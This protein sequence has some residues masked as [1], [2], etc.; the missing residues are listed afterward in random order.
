MVSKKV[1]NLTYLQDSVNVL[2]AGGDNVQ[3]GRVGKQ[4]NLE[5][6]NQWL[7]FFFAGDQADRFALRGNH[8]DGSQKPSDFNTVKPPENQVISANEFKKYLRTDTCNYDEVRDGD[9]LY[10]YKDYPQYKV[11]LVLVDSIDIPNIV[12]S[13]GKLKYYG[14]GQMGFQERQLKWIANEALGTCPDDYHVVMFS[15]VPIDRSQNDAGS[16]N[17]E[18]LISIIKAFMN[19]TTA[20]ITTSTVSEYSTDFSVNF[21]VDFSKRLNSNFVGYVAGHSHT[22]KVSKIEGFNV[23]VCRQSVFEDWQPAELVGTASEDAMQ[24]IQ[25]DTSNRELII[26]GYG[27]STNRTFTY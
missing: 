3:S 21:S 27:R 17:H 19:R 22:E 26:L 10:G 8:D 9:S 6:M 2:I 12:D 13:S 20:N 14:M 25:V 5:I 11:R 7:S 4:L 24:I 23:V 18:C 16:I 15:H 1:N